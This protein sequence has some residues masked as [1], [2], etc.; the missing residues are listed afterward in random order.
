MLQ[1]P[2]SRKNVFLVGVFDFIFRSI[3]IIKY[4]YHECIPIKEPLRGI[5]SLIQQCCTEQKKIF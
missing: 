3:T 2:L 4:I 1:S 5:F